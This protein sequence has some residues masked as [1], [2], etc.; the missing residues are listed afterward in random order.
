M[1]GKTKTTKD[2][3]KSETENKPLTQEKIRQKHVDIRKYELNLLL[4][5]ASAGVFFDDEGKKFIPAKLSTALQRFY[6][7]VTIVETNEIYVYHEKTGLYEEDGDKFIKMQVKKALRDKYLPWRSNA[8]VDDVRTCT[9]MRHK[10]FYDKPLHF[11]PFENGIFDISKHP[12]GLIPYNEKYYFTSKLPVTYDPEATSPKFNKYLEEVLP[13][14]FERDRLQEHV[15]YLLY[16]RN[17]FEVNA[18]LTGPADSGKSTFL[19]LLQALLGDENYVNI[20]LQDLEIDKFALANLHQKYACVYADLQKI[21]LETSGFIR[22]ISSGDKISAQHKHKRRFDFVPRVKLWF[23]A[24]EPPTTY[25]TSDAF[26]KR[27]D[28]FEFPNRFPLGHP[29]RNN[30]LINELTTPEELSGILNWALEG[31]KRLLSNGFFSGMSS[32]DVRREMWL[33]KA[34]SLYR[35]V[36]TCV[37]DSYSQFVTKEDFYGTYSLYCQDNSLPVLSVKAVGSLLPRYIPSVRTYRPTINCRQVS[38][39]KGIS[40]KKMS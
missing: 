18:L 25:D 34:N 15:G 9:Y 14:T 22:A 7:F 8:V 24:N 1:G 39:W 23:S 38:A 12:W 37:E 29:N 3:A 33:F 5:G 31:L 26:F 20:T 2:K 11:I 21:T 27:W 28:I 36:K 30:F 19:K 32:I 35:F 13:N 16:P 6:P 4:S 40:I 17:N 10:E